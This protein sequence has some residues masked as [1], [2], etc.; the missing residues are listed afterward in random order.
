MCWFSGFSCN[1]KSFEPFKSEKHRQFFDLDEHLDA[2]QDSELPSPE[3]VLDN[4]RFLDRLLKNES[5]PAPTIIDEAVM[6]PSPGLLARCFTQ[7]MTGRDFA[8]FWL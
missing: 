8:L 3:T 1:N 5:P 2:C 4:C 6:G 7:G